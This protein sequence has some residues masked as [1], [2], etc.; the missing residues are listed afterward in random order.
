M[1]AMSSFLYENPENPNEVIDT[2]WGPLPAWKASTIA[3]GKM[4]AYDDYMKT[5]RADAADALT[6]I[7]DAHARA[8]ALNEREANLNRREG[9][10]NAKITLFSDAVSRF[11]EMVEQ[12]VQ[13][14][15]DM[16]QDEEELQELE[17][18]L[19][20]GELHT[21]PAKGT[22][23]PGGTQD[24]DDPDDPIGASD[25]DS[26]GDLPRDLTMSELGNYPTL[27]DPPKPQVAPP[28]SVSLNNMEDDDDGPLT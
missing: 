7:A 3:T 26:E 4:G 12:E 17:T 19:P 11:A 27:E 28:V 8:D 10:L 22:Q 5:I 13:R 23:D 21:I 14:K 2:P 25:E 9:E 18:I 6:R 16:A 20:G 15:A 24:P 1:P